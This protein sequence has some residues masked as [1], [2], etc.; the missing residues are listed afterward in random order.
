MTEHNLGALTGLANERATLVELDG[1]PICV[2]RVN[3]SVYAIGD[4]CSHGQISLAEGE[5][6]CDELEIECWKHGSAFSLTTGVPSTLPATQ[7]VPTY[8]TSIRN[9]DVVIEV[10]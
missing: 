10:P 1:H 7:P 2:V 4:T 5:V 3:N 9:G 8:V 6:Y